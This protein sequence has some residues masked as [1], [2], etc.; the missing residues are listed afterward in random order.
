VGAAGNDA[1]AAEPVQPQTVGQVNDDA[2]AQREGQ[3]ADAV[4]A[5]A[6]RKHGSAIPR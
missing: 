6:R 5:F 4:T 1:A 3:D 2:A